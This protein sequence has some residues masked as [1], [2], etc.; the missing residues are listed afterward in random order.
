MK[1][2]KN[3]KFIEDN[4][5][6]LVISS[7]HK[8]NYKNFIF[9]KKVFKLKILIEHINV[10]FSREILKLNQNFNRNLYNRY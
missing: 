7:D 5:E 8:G 3:S 10:I 6:A 1:T 2:T 4:N 9:Y